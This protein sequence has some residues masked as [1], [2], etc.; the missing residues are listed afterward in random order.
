MAIVGYSFK[1]IRQASGFDRRRGDSIKGFAFHCG[2]NRMAVFYIQ[3]TLQSGNK[4]TSKKW[5]RL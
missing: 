1:M 5:Q 4:L 3:K 2:S